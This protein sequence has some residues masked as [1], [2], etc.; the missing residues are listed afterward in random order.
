MKVSTNQAIC[1][2]LFAIGFAWLVSLGSPSKTNV[3]NNSDEIHI[4][5]AQMGKHW[6]F[7]VSEGDIV[8][9]HATGSRYGGC[10]VVFRADGE[11]YAL[12]ATAKDIHERY[13]RYRNIEDI[14]AFDKEA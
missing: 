3:N 2:I 12:T 14:W 13:H 1:L 4:T 8:I 7:T 9:D 10:P 6:P 11:D 5:K